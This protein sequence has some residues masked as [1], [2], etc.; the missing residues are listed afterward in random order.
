M[1][2]TR[3][4]VRRLP[5]GNRRYRKNDAEMWFTVGG[6]VFFVMRHWYFGWVW[7]D[8]W[9]TDLT[10]YPTALRAFHAAV[11]GIER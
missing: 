11:K 3:S 8:G 4:L 10:R 1:S 7:N 9:D 5:S 6:T 2:T